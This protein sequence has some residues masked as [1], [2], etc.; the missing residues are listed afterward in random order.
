MIYTE[1]RARRHRPR[2]DQVHPHRLPTRLALPALEELA[3]PLRHRHLDI[4][5]PSTTIYRRYEIDMPFGVLLAR[6][7]EVEV[8]RLK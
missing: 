4:I 7:G 6:R 2:N 8:G 3:Q 5:I 1:T